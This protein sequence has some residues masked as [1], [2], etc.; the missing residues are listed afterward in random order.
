MNPPCE[1]FAETSSESL[2]YRPW[3]SVT[4]TAPTP[5][6]TGQPCRSLTRSFLSGCVALGVLYDHKRP[7]G[8]L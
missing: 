6:A 8:R 7:T 2:D 4:M 1:A 3:T 5:E